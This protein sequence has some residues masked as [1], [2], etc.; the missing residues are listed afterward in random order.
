MKISLIYSEFPTN[1]INQY[2]IGVLDFDQLYY[3]SVGSYSKLLGVIQELC[4]KG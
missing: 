2:Q 3:V 1:V 4:L